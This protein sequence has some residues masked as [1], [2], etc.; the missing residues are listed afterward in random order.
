LY[1]SRD[2]A[3]VIK[4]FDWLV[5]TYMK[6]CTV[7]SREFHSVQATGSIVLATRILENIDSE[8]EDVKYH[9]SIGTAM[10]NLF[11]FVCKPFHTVATVETV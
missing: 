1:P 8:F 11:R 5:E 2:I 6:E 9:Q 7:E 4:P 3:D 10:G